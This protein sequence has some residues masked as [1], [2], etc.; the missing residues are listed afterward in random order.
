M[1][2]KKQREIHPMELETE[3]LHY[4]HYRASLKLPP[5]S[6][7]TSSFL[8][9][10][11]LLA[12]AATSTAAIYSINDTREYVIHPRLLPLI[13]DEIYQMPEKSR[14]LNIE[15]SDEESI[16]NESETEV[17]RMLFIPLR[18]E[19]AISLSQSSESESIEEVYPAVSSFEKKRKQPKKV[20]GA[21]TPRKALETLTNRPQKSDFSP[22]LRIEEEI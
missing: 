7:S 3:R 12:N 8:S 2:H 10:P 16:N 19:A 20:L 22:R 6:F 4:S 21:Q 15:G 11:S 9:S 14:F 5:S 17:S 13:D 18:G 1:K